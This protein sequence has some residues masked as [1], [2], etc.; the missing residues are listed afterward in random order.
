M[1]AKDMF[2]RLG[3]KYYKTMESEDNINCKKENYKIVFRLKS[4]N[5]LLEKENNI[6]LLTKDML[7]AINQQYKEL[8]WLEQEQKDEN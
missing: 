1:K 3:Y 6:F 8:G 2:E 5:I 4:E 7:Q